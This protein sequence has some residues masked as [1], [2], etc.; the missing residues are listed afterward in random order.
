MNRQIIRIGELVTVSY[1]LRVGVGVVI[2]VYKRKR[3]LKVEQLWCLYSYEISEKRTSGR[4]MD[5]DRRTNV[6]LRP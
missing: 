6:R 3:S 4:Y 1:E 2:F 5:N